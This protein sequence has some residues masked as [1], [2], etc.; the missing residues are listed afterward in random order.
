MPLPGRAH[1]HMTDILSLRVARVQAIAAGA[2]AVLFHDDAGLLPAFEAGQFLTLVLSIKGRE[3]RR[4]Y[5]VYTRPDELPAIGIAVKRVPGGLVSNHIADH[6]REGDVLQAIPPIGHFTVNP[7]WPMAA[8]LVFF[9]AGS[10]ITP[11]CSIIGT[12]RRTQP[13]RPLHLFYCNSSQ[14]STMFKNELEAL[15]LESDGKLN[16][17]QTLSQP[18]PH[19][20][21]ACGRFT[22]E[23][24]ADLVRSLNIIPALAHYFVCGPEGMMAQVVQGLMALG[25]DGNNIHKENFYHTTPTAL[26]LP[27]E[28]GEDTLI[29]RTVT[30][31]YNGTDNEVH[32]AADESILAAALEMGLDLPYACQMGIC[33]M[34]RARLIAGRI[35]IGEQE[36]IS[37]DEIANGDCLTCVGHPLSDG[38][39]IDYD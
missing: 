12:L 28:G 9:G 23:G 38:V 3:V 15:A 29:D 30:I 31:R 2:V 4:S 10:G 37:E 22:A 27:D 26:P 6:V 8:P 33:G 39:V 7:T 18:G 13:N 11:M 32:V 35:H 1:T 16:L 25:V 20:Q 19:W 34:C 36:A 14:E 5:S 17:H 24:T 21:G